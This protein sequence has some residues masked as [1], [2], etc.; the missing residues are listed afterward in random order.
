MAFVQLADMNSEIELVIFPK[1]YAQTADIWLRDQV[2][3]A[4]GKIGSGRGG[5]AGGSE[6]KI[7]VD[8]AK[9]L[10]R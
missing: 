8:E 10:N 1:T 3:I 4:K 7:L 6:R 5:G 9:L 2:I